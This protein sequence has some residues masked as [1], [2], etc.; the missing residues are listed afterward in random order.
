M[1][2]D[3]Y[4]WKHVRLVLGFVQA[5]YQSGATMAARTEGGVCV[6]QKVFFVVCLG[7]FFPLVFHCAK[8]SVGVA[9]ENNQPGTGPLFPHGFKYNI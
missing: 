5:C 6:K 7:V 2:Q 1:I 3:C 4:E 8:P 9:R